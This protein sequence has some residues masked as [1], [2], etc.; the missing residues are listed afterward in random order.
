MNFLI[1]PYLVFFLSFLLSY[2]STFLG[3]SDLFYKLNFVTHVIYISVCALFLVLGIVTY[4]SFKNNISFN[5]VDIST[6]E[7]LVFA[8]ITLFFIAEC[9]FSGY[10]PLFLS[11]YSEILEAKFG[12]PLLHGLFVSFLSYKS[13]FYYQ[14]YLSGNGIRAIIYLFAVN[15]IILFLMRRGLLVFNA[16]A[17]M[18][19]YIVHSLDSGE[20]TRYVS[21]K[22]VGAS[23]I[24]LVLFGLV[25]NLRIADETGDYILK[26]GKASQKFL[27]SGIPKVFFF[28]YMYLSSPVNIFDANVFEYYQD[29]SNYFVVK[30]I[31]PDFIA[32]RFLPAEDVR[33]DL[34]EVA[35]FNAGGF[36]IGP[37]LH[38]RISGIV[39]ILIYYLFISI[40]VRKMVFRK[41]KRSAMALCLFLAITTLLTFSN[42]LNKGGYI[43]PLFMAMSFTD[44]KKRFGVNC[45]AP[46][47]GGAGK[48]PFPDSNENTSPILDQ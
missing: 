39:F 40:L 45:M 33:L 6:G 8:C 36:F 9:L 20:H 35:G 43:L 31:L 22:L 17:C 19:M 47:S 18:F 42:L 29:S 10:I 12:I 2:L 4:R 23:M 41:K 15:L 11:D 26:V 3:W 44:L 16:L 37:Y 48:Q 13:I 5:N 30:N 14:S 46:A 21:I 1:N 28:G 24:T 7:N 27:D 34:V 25:G 32:K 38:S